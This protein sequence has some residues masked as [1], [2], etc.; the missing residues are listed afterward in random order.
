[1]GEGKSSGS[2]EMRGGR[3]VGGMGLWSMQIN[4]LFCSGFCLWCNNFHFVLCGMLAS[5]D[6]GIVVFFLL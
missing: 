6:N 3:E 2:R 5:W 1:M 4:L